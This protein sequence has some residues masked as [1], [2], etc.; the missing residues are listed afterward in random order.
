M[1]F[2]TAAR[3]SNWC[4]SLKTTRHRLHTSLCN[5]HG[6]A[7][8]KWAVADRTLSPSCPQLLWSLEGNTCPVSSPTPS[9]SS[10]AL[11]TFPLFFVSSYQLSCSLPSL[12]T[13]EASLVLRSRMQVL[14]SPKWV[15]CCGC[16]WS[17]Q[18]AQTAEHQYSTTHSFLSKSCVTVVLLSTL[19]QLLVLMQISVHT[20]WPSPLFFLHI[21]MSLLQLTPGCICSPVPSNNSTFARPALTHASLWKKSLVLWRDYITRKK[22][23]LI[24]F[25]GIVIGIN[26]IFSTELSEEWKKKEN[27]IFTSTLADYNLFSRLS[28]DLSCSNTNNPVSDEREKANAVLPPSARIQAPEVGQ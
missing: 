21:F 26:I 14:H 13:P 3:W 6:T 28:D 2:I 24:L 5:T 1:R 19:L 27:N 7:E 9:H 22:N 16:C 11:L 4:W 17:C 10:S 20:W 18:E 23:V 12:M 15:R 8:S 25:P